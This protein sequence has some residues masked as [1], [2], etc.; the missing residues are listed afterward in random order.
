MACVTDEEARSID[1]TAHDLRLD[2]LVEVH[3]EAE[4]NRALEL[5]TKLV[6]IN[7]RDLRS[8]ETKLEICE[9]LTEKIPADRI[10]VTESGISTHE[11]CLRL[12]ARHRRFSSAK[13]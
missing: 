9:R 1:K 7:N 11:D 3:D 8:F 12:K 10:V 6:G 2:I 13:A 5:E 4:L